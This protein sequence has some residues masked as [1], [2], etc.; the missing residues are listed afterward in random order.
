M[1]DTVTPF[2][3]VPWLHLNNDKHSFLIRAYPIWHWQPL[4][5]SI[6]VDLHVAILLHDEDEELGVKVPLGLLSIHW[7][8]PWLS[9]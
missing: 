2:Q 8:T 9:T 4:P 6:Y 1:H 5:A 7:Q 3:V